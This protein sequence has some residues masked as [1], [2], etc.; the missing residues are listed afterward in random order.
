MDEFGFCCKSCLVCNTWIFLTCSG[1]VKTI[2][3]TCLIS[4]GEDFL[5]LCFHVGNLIRADATLDLIACLRH[6][7]YQGG[8]FVFI[9][10]P[11]TYLVKLAMLGTSLRSEPRH[12][13]AFPTEPRIHRGCIL[14]SWESIS[15]AMYSK[16][17]LLYLP[18]DLHNSRGEQSIV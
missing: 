17:Q 6:L 16:D 3:W 2:S 13:H 15:V 14:C 12:N 10:T 1:Q 5:H 8:F 7:F 9:G 4:C 18:Q 11:Q